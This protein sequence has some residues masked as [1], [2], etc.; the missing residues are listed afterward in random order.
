VKKTAFSFTHFKAFLFVC[1]FAFAIGYSILD[2]RDVLVNNKATQ[3]GE[4]GHR[5]SLI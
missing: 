5:E 4:D 3:A 2:Q 1:S